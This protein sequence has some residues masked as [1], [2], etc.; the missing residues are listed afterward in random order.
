MRLRPS[1]LLTFAVVGAAC[2]DSTGTDA[3]A[4]A[5]EPS[6]DRARAIYEVRFLSQRIAQHHM[7]VELAGMCF[8]KAVHEELRPEC[9]AVGRART[10]EITTMQSWLTSWY[11]LDYEPS[12]Q[13]DEVRRMERLASLSGAEFEVA[14]LEEMIRHHRAAIRE[15]QQCARR[16]HHAALVAMCRAS[17]AARSPEIERISAWLAAWYDR[18]S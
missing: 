12:V 15:S 3:A 10:T 1:L 9:V 13:P 7:A 2:A 5:L 11:A 17:V 6:P 14:F 18:H 4:A 16:A 8:E